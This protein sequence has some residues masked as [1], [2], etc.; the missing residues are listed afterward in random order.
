MIATGSI[1]I[2]ANHS[3]SLNAPMCEQPIAQDR[4][5][6]IIEEDVWVGAGCII[7]PGAHI[8]HGAVI[9]AGAVVRGFVPANKIFGGVPARQ[10]GERK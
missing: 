4:L 6:I 1:L 8:A 7:L 5:G 2:G 10:I 3:I 9:A